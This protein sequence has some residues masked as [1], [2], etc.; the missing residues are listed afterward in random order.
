MVVVGFLRE[1][2]VP[3]GAPMGSSGSIGVVGF[4][5]VHPGGCQVHSVAPC[6]SS[7]SFRVVGFIWVCPRGRWVHWE[8]LGSLEVVRY[9][10]VR[11]GIC[12]ERRFTP[13]L[14][15]Q[16]H[17]VRARGRQFRRPAVQRLHHQSSDQ[18]PDAAHTDD[19]R[20]RAKL[21]MKYGRLLCGWLFGELSYGK[22]NG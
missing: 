17:G 18:E 10:W 6:Q 7:G 21:A 1:P 19:S 3:W 2:F 12:R 11:P 5:R 9:I 16:R 22:A 8:P 14:D 4:I 20:K 13:R 15:A